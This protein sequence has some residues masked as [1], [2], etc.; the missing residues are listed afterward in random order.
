[1]HSAFLFKEVKFDYI[2]CVKKVDQRIQQIL[3][4]TVIKFGLEQYRLETWDVRQ[5]FNDLGK[6]SYVLMAQWFPN[7]LSKN[8]EDDVSPDGTVSITYMIQE[9]R[10]E[11]VIFVN[12][13]SYS[14]QMLFTHK[15]VEEVAA[16]VENET[17]LTFGSGFRL[18]EA[19]ENGYRFIIDVDGIPLSPNYTIEVKF[20]D[21]GHLT[22]FSNEGEVPDTTKVE[23]N[24]FTLHLEEIEQLVKQQLQLVHFPS[25]SK[26]QF[27]SVYAIEEVFI[28]VESKKI[29]PY[30]MHERAE[31]QVSQVLSWESPATTVLVKKDFL[32]NSEVI[33]DEAFKMDTVM[34]VTEL[35]EE[36]IENSLLLT[37][38][39][40]RTV[41]PN[42]SGRWEIETIR[43]ENDYIQVKCSLIDQIPTILARKFIVFVEPETYTLLDYIDNNEMFS[44]FESFTPAKAACITHEE[45]FEKLFS[46]IS[47]DPTY[48]YDPK[49]N[50]YI[51]CG[52]L[53]AAEGIDAVTGEIVALQDL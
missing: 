24:A 34:T 9:Q 32:Y 27:R 15:T 1:M 31:L 22:L 43:R 20:D 14:S 35:T 23:K 44:V 8:I 7:D 45:A 40:I 52:L 47:L 26:K 3:D 33:L 13:K 37:K 4:E 38:E 42:D 12:G 53:D 5:L 11:R 29:L 50:N 17:G 51:L 19:Q 10:Y 41:F 36:A 46:Y 28:A 6:Q 49:M 18:N 16:W 30:Y 21:F 25:E 2:R 48:V 39:V